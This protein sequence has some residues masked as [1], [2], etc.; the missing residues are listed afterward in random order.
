MGKSQCIAPPALWQHLCHELRPHVLPF[1]AYPIGS[2]PQRSSPLLSDH[3]CH[4]QFKH[5]GFSKT[6][7]LHCCETGRWVLFDN[8]LPAATICY[9]ISH[10]SCWLL[11]DMQHLCKHAMMLMTWYTCI[12]H[13]HHDCSVRLVTC[14]ISTYAH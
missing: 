13:V 1:A 5:T 7:Y 9:C 12:A 11:L 3:H 2:R 4:L 10:G 6:W 8:D 14:A